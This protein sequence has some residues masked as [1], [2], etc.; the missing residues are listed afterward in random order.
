MTSPA[1]KR[2]VKT[3]R[4]RAS[5]LA[6]VLRTQGE[7]R[8]GRIAMTPPLS[9]GAH[10]SA[11]ADAANDMNGHGA[12]GVITTL[13]TTTLFRVL[14]PG[15]V[16]AFSTKVGGVSP[17]PRRMLNLG[18]ASHDSLEN[19]EENRRRF[20]SALGLDAMPKVSLRQVHGDEVHFVEKLPAA[21]LQGDGVFTDK[22]DLVV[23][24]AT[25]D[26]APILFAEREGRFVGAVHAGW[27]G[28][29]KGVA[30]K[31]VREAGARYGAKPADLL[32]AIGPCIKP[33]CYRV[34]G[35]VVR[36]FRDASLPLDSFRE[37]SEDNFAFDL[38]SENARQLLESGLPPANMEILDRCTYCEDALF[39]SF[40]REGEGVG[41]MMSVI[42]RVS[43]GV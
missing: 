29:A 35:D 3:A 4:T 6:A 41:H 43:A 19:V 42:A 24:V 40:R 20:F 27:R 28:A 17:K 21:T 22:E 15:I 30:M 11:C 1:R 10:A 36:A 13:H 8:E 39:F 12:E 5:G 32:A 31:A 37:V 33:C 26:C 14:L 9:D 7:L 2:N 34:K 16:H 38:A 25:A 23:G 18:S